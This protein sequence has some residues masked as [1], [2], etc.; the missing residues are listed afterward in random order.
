MESLP[1]LRDGE[2]DIVIHP[3]STCYV[4]NVIPVFREVARITRAG[5]LYIS[6]HKQ[7]ASL[8][9]SIDPLAGGGYAVAQTYYRHQPIPPS[10]SE[11][12]SARRL[13]ERGAVEFVHRWEELIGGMCRSGFAIEDLTEPMHAKKSEPGSF[14]DRASY[15]PP[16]VRIKARRVGTATQSSTAS[17]LWLPSAE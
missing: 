16:Y 14:A 5:G 17:K 4:P 8:Q 13:R 11:L 2:F 6:Q 12:P 15:L 7:P 9:S 1:M 3:V 10:T